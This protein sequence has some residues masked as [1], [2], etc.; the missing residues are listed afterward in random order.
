[1]KPLNLILGGIM[2]LIGLLILYASAQMII[3]AFRGISGLIQGALVTA[4]GAA[5]VYYGYK[6]ARKE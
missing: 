1:M 6:R 2:I 5:L 3:H 4:I